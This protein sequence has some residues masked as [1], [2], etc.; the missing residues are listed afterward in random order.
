MNKETILKLIQSP[1]Y[2][3][4]LLGL[5]YLRHI[6][7]QEI[8]EMVKGDPKVMRI[9]YPSVSTL[10]GTY[11]K[12]QDDLYAYLSSTVVIFRKKDELVAGHKIV[13]L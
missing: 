8:K 5:S 11:Y 10:I 12:V 3:D 4:K 9:T 7:L 6:P 2:D 13:E 1:N